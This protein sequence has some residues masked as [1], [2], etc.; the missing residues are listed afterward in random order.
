MKNLQPS[1]N[2]SLSSVSFI[3]RQ[4]SRVFFCR[5]GLFISKLDGGE[6]LFFLLSSYLHSCPFSKY[7]QKIF[8]TFCDI[9]WLVVCIW[10]FSNLLQICM[11][12]NGGKIRFLANFQRFF[13]NPQILRDVKK[14]TKYV[15]TA[16]IQFE[17]V[18]KSHRSRTN[19]MLAFEYFNVGYRKLAQIQPRTFQ[20]L[21]DLL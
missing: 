20:S 1:P 18:H 17:A 12:F 11:K 8:W 4:S 3:F 2:S 14:Y 19:S 21:D 7:L 16:N 5:P 6:G 9:I 10:E 13:K 15:R